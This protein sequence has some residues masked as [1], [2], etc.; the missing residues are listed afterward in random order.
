MDVRCHAVT[1]RSP[2]RIPTSLRTVPEKEQRPIAPRVPVTLQTL[3]PPRPRTPPRAGGGGGGG[4]ATPKASQLWTIP[5]EAKRATTPRATMSVS[6]IAGS[7]P[8]LTKFSRCNQRIAVHPF[9]DA[10]RAILQGEPSYRFVEHPYQDATRSSI[11]V[12]NVEVFNTAI[13]RYSSTLVSMPLRDGP[14]SH[15]LQEAKPIGCDDIK[16]AHPRHSPMRRGR[17]DF[18]DCADIAGATPRQR[19][20]SPVRVNSSLNTADIPG[21]RPRIRSPSP[22]RPTTANNPAPPQ[23]QAYNPHPQ[24]WGY[25]S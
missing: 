2:V 23:R 14:R 19:S 21:A 6:D 17:Q 9:A 8:A 16:G 12:K 25:S 13:G 10:H 18:F 1:S 22:L 15:G 24:W 11:R 7:R 3:P 4:G 5:N 20:R